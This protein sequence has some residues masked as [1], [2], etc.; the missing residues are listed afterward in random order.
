MKQ[1]G[2]GY[3][4]LIALSFLLASCQKDQ[5]FGF[6]KSIGKTVTIDRPVDANFTKIF[7]NDDVNLVITQGNAYSIKLEGGEN[8]LPGITTT[9]SDSTLTIRNNNTFNWLR[10]YDYKITAYVTLPHIF[11]LEY[12][13][14]STVTNTDTLREDSLTVTSTGGSGYIDLVIKTG[15]SKLSITSGSA[16]MKISGTTGLNFIYSGS[17]GPFKCLGLKS[18]FLYMENA[19]TNDCYVNV[20]SHLE[21]KISGLGNI[22]YTG[23]P[24][25]ISGSTTDA[26]RLIKYD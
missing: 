20:K 1:S 2:K 3:L 11:V 13:A 12:K 23:N 24:P 15:V 7:L 22:Y 14:T 8:L 17:Y 4:F 26:G 21:Y 19:S 6:A 18:D 5:L 16:D 9:F 10:S 25:E